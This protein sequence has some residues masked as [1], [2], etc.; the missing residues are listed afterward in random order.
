MN[1]LL[2]DWIMEHQNKTHKQAKSL[3]TKEQI[4]VNGKPQ[5]KYNYLVKETDHIVI[6][7]AIETEKWDI[8]ILYEDSNIIVVNK[9]SGLLT[10]GTE[11]EKENTLYNVMSSYLKTKQ[12]QAKIFIVHRLDKDT[13]GVVL[14]AK[15][16]RIKTLYQDHWE[17]IV[18]YRGYIALIE[19]TLNK[20]ED[21]ITVY[22]EEN[23]QYQMYVSKSGK[24]AITKYKVLKENKNY[25]KL[26]I[27]LLTGRKNQIRITFSHI[28]HPILGDEKYGA[29][30]IPSL[31]LGLHAHKLILIDP[32]T[33]KEFVFEA[34]IPQHFNKFI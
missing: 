26:E 25:S 16:E 28:G 12:K 34:P 5:T 4:L 23:K 13:S 21:I 31:K 33:K 32:I 7:K 2:I 18:K 14:L 8:P 10:I 6:K 9:P 22:L 1:Q 15:S 3:L 27:E 29:K 24:K 19:G 30:K 20:K 11:K 17:D